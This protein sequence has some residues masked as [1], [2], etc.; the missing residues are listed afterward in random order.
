M[1]KNILTVLS[2]ALGLSASAQVSDST[3]LGAGYA[4]QSYYSL[5]NGEVA[6]V[7]NNNWDLAFDLSGFGSTIRLNRRVNVMYVYPGDTANWMTVDTAGHTSWDSYVN[8]FESWSEGAFNADADLG[9]PS[10][11]GWGIYNTLS[12]FTEGDRIFV[13]ELS[14]G[15][16]RKLWI[17]LLASGVYTFKYDYLDNS[18]EQNITL[19]K[20]DY[21][22]KNFI[23]YSLENDVVVDREPINTDWDL[24][25][26]NYALE[27]APN[28]ISTV[29]GVLQNK[30]CYVQEVNDVPANEAAYYDGDLEFNI[31][32][33]GYDWKT[34]NFGNFSYD[35]EDSLSY[36]VQTAEGDVWQLIFTGF[37]GSSDGKSYFT[38]ELIG[39]ASFEEEELTELVVYPN[40][41]IDELNVFNMENISQLSLYNMNGQQ[42]F[43]TANESNTN[44]L[45]I[46]LSNF[47]QG[48]YLIHAVTNTQS[49][50]SQKV[51]ITNK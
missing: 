16:Y 27:L 10:D 2:W 3:E 39:A 38:K 24:V 9:N 33:V 14:D 20:S 45:Q 19:T 35:I 50:I 17:E 36:Y 23:Y 13:V 21:S 15:S 30:E 42:V 51:V 7:D 43:T 40:P 8:G 37:N 31:S 6:N 29:T 11:L 48:V 34:F 49:I 18:D 12:H 32:T 47:D 4:S 25:F 28:Y 1:K 41:A 22:D 26:T 46:D 5:E 44:L